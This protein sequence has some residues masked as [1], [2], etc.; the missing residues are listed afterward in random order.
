MQ[1]ESKPNDHQS[2]TT[3]PF[4]GNVPI[5][6]ALHELRLR[7]LDL[8]GRNRLVNFKH[9][10]GKSL[11]FVHTSIENT[12]RR[13]VDDP[14]NRV[15]IM[16]IQ[17][18]DRGEWVSRGGGKLARPE[19]KDFAQRI[20][21]DP[22][23]ELVRTTG[24]VVGAPRPA[25]QARTLF[26]AE[27][28]G[29][30]GRK[31]ER[32]ARLAIEE[33]GANMLYLVFGFLEFPE[34][35]QSDKQFLAPLVCVPVSMTR[36]EDGQYST[37]IL[38]HTGEELA[39]NLSLREKIKRDFGLNLPE[40][41]ED[42][43]I[44][45]YFDAV[46]KAIVKL[47]N[48]RV[49]RMMTLTLLSFANMLLVRDLDPEN[50][51]KVNKTSILLEHPLV[52]QVF[53]GKPDFGSAQYAEEYRID[54]HPRGDLPIIYDADSSQ[55]S[56]LI[57]VMDG[58][59]RV[60]EGPPGTGK[61]QTIT[62]LIAAALHSG[63]KVLFVSEKL[64]ALEVVKSRL[65][66]AD[67]APFVLELH[68]NKANKKR[69]LEEL[70]ARVSM[71]IQNTRDLP[72]LLAQQEQKRKEL[73]AYADLMNSKVG[74]DLNLSLHQVIWRAELNRLRCG[75][76]A[77]AVQNL[78]YAAAPS[79]TSQEMAAY[80]DRLRY[81]ASQ[82][83]PIG[84][85]GPTHPMWGFFP[86]EFK[87]EDHLPVQRA[88]TD[89]SNKFS[90]FLLALEQAAVLLGGSNLNMS[91]KSA[92]QLVSV[93]ERLNPND[94]VAF[95]LLAQLFSDADPHGVKSLALLNDLEA[96]AAAIS[97]AESEIA[98]C[99]VRTQPAD[100][101][102]ATACGAESARLAELGIGSMSSESL[103][104]ARATL[105]DVAQKTTESLK[106]LGRTAE[107]LSI[108]FSGNEPEIRKLA[109]I[110]KVIEAAPKDLLTLLHSGLKAPGTVSALE[111]SIKHL[112]ATRELRL[113]LSPGFYLD[114][115]PPVD[116]LS[117]AI[118][119][120][121]EGD[122][123]YR[124]FQKRWRSALNTHRQLQRTKEKRSAT[125]RQHE[126]EQIRKL[127]NDERSWREDLDLH[128]AA[129]AHFRNEQTPLADLLTV[130]RWVE[131]SIKTLEEAQISTAEFDPTRLDRSTTMALLAKAKEVGAALDNLRQFERESQTLLL[132]AGSSVRDELANADWK[133][134]LAK[135]EAAIETIA[136][137]EQL[138]SGTVRP[139]V[140][141][142][143]GLS[144][145]RTSY[146]LPQ[147]EAE[148]NAHVE[149]GTLFGSTYAGR[150]TELHAAFAAHAYGK[151]IK[152]QQLPPSIERTLLSPNG[153]ENRRLLHS[154]TSA[155]AAGWKAVPDFTAAM[156]SFGR[157]VATEWADPTGC[158]S[159]QYAKRLAEKTK[160]AAESA[161]GLLAWT[162]YVGA[163][164][165]VTKAGLEGFVV[166]LEMG[167]IPPEKLEH[168]FLYRFYS[169][170]AQSAFEK[171]ATLRKFS[172][173]RHTAV[174]KEFA[175]LDKQI[176]QMRGRAVAQECRRI[177]RPPDGTSG[178]R[179]ADKTEME[180]L[181]LLIPQQRPRVPVRQM[182]RR[183]GKAI[184][185]LKPCFMMGPQAVAQFLAPGYLHF[186][187]VVMDEAS[188]LRPEEA[189]GAIARGSQLVVVG[190]PKQLPPTSFFARIA[191]A[192]G[193][194]DDGQGPLTT[195]EAESI[196]DVCISHFRPVR[197]LRWHYRSRHESL[198]A[199]SNH[200]FYRG[201]LV[202]FPSPYP[203]S[204]ALGLRYQY[205]GDG[206]YENQMNHVEALRV[207]DA[208]VEHILHRPDDSLGIVTLN[209][210]QRDLISELLEERLRTLPQAVEFKERWNSEGMGLFIKNLENVQGDERDCIFISTTFGK[211]R[212]TEVVRQ[213]FGP[214][215][216]SGGWRRLNVLF[217]RSRKSVAVFSSMRPEDIV[218]DAKTP[219]GTRALR[220]YLEYARSGILPVEQETEL[221]PDSDFEI[222]VMDVLRGRGYVVEPQLGVAGFRIDIGVRHPIHKSGYLAAIECDGA[223]YHSGVSV[224]DRDRIR[225]EILESIGWRN[226]IWRI[227][228]TDWFRNP[229]A[230]SERMLRFLEELAQQPIPDE[231]LDSEPLPDSIGPIPD[232]ADTVDDERPE[233]LVFSDDEE[234]LEAQVGDLVT[235]APADFPDKALRVRITAKQT[236]PDLG[237]V[238]ESTPLGSVLMGAMIGEAVVLRV[239]GK[240]PQSFVIQAI[241]RFSVEASR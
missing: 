195:T 207:V 237:L 46:S 21:I 224:R 131:T 38:N 118:H 61:S 84:S 67:L 168:A 52:K 63:K 114:A 36:T 17:E 10:A 151:S 182:L 35:H 135:V 211:A 187:I 216:R 218:V 100:L 50:W 88:L 11:Q 123:W 79:T 137:V 204:K 188:Q 111:A 51:P 115:I 72:D 3:N 238:A 209:I 105:Q 161:D 139:G 27:D 172:G 58:K 154:Y 179:V 217:T 177:A 190:D 60:I 109:A 101:E 181:N 169:A 197:T 121:R 64:A 62:N 167:E 147:L 143:S 82:L 77:T 191:S 213:S 236:N 173:I 174:R 40:Y 176:I 159:S 138:M 198:I 119:T 129:G 196:L 171:T 124:T 166:Q 12:F 192:D 107:V 24:R 140:S 55:H 65:A 108:Q 149:A 48:W 180:L 9:T 25:T 228:S 226:R 97:N 219:E 239:P 150:R 162:Q 30:H 133:R 178:T 144:A 208:A 34:S 28:L 81:I 44:E 16:P 92:E 96:K 186:D 134:R 19:P 201:D 5:K 31:L 142:E 54:E 130:A 102:H 94:E 93:L 66:L 156:S 29:R 2:P 104:E 7:L 85:Y 158:S 141:A 205:I 221:P 13:L 206:I 200:H 146:S 163:R 120:F 232:L 86:E 157:F 184:Q 155:I 193:D 227:W 132:S 89:F 87:P 39:D 69:V 56:A 160:Q 165:E 152:A 43:S 6:A 210:K 199:F 127:V 126:L 234:E 32:E 95:H 240:P 116:L 33:T 1:G 148:L 241:S 8:T 214:I 223:T 18:P 128:A 125:D 136:R 37:F 183:A 175:E 59:N 110:A 230:E 235:Y 70:G 41:D 145:V 98:R 26:Y 53:E 202:V 220:S 185:E 117:E 91:A 99:L 20:G 106:R 153:V 83:A 225:Q 164:S 76:S 14:G 68:S 113:L 233:D 4:A 90:S 22:S 122:A 80:C 73:K 170:V 203:K 194:G 231:Y 47:P 74:R 49:R 212:G 15:T 229:L 71:R 215:S 222:A 75:T 189:I 57:D 78:G 103:A 45:D 112:Q 42:A 23:Y